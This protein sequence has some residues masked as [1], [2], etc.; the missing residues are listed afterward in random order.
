MISDRDGEGATLNALAIW[1]SDRGEVDE[2]EA[3]QL[4]ALDIGRGLGLR[5]LEGQ[6]LTELGD[7]YRKQ[8]RFS[9]ARDTLN[10][11]L[12]VLDNLSDNYY[13]AI[14]KCYM[15]HLHVALGETDAAVVMMSEANKLA[16][17]LST[18]PRSELGR[19]IASAQQ[20]VDSLTDQ[21]GGVAGGD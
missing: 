19:Y 8:N 18:S 17:E 15:A 3:M 21:T 9:E 1:L 10:Q 13:L 2:A 16:I 14:A 4:A 20:A 6:V 12:E 11:A 7:V 5:S